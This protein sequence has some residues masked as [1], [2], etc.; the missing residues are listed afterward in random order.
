[1]CPL[2]R[3]FFLLC[4]LLRVSIIR[5]ST[6]Y[7][8]AAGLIGTDI[9]STTHTDKLMPIFDWK[10]RNQA[11]KAIWPAMSPPSQNLQLAEI[12][13]NNR[14]VLQEEGRKSLLSLWQHRLTWFKFCRPV[15]DTEPAYQKMNT[16][17]SGIP[18]T[19]HLA[20]FHLFTLFYGEAIN[21]LMSNL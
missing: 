5:G 21:S 14:V 13:C 8:I 7:T 4:P 1:M 19:A 15:A 9:R 20:L 18:Q 3:G 10:S 17:L 11:K 6:V 2:Q 16:L 12:V